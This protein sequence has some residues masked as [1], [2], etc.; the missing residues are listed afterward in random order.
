MLKKKNVYDALCTLMILVAE[1][2][3]KQQQGTIELATKKLTQ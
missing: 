2:K 1:E 3:V